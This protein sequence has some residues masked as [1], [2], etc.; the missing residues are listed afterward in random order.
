MSYCKNC[1]TELQSGARFC[2]FCGTPTEIDRIPIQLNGNGEP[3]YTGSQP[4]GNGEPAYTGGQPL[5]NGESPYAGGQP[6]G[7]AGPVY[8]NSQPYG[9]GEPAY[10][11]S[12]PL[13]NGE[14]P[15]AGGQPYGN[16]EPTYVSGQPYGNV[17]PV[18]ANGQP[19][20]N[21]GP[22]YAGGQ[23]YGNGEPT[24]ANGQVYGNGEQSYPNMSGYAGED[25][26]FAGNPYSPYGAA[27]QPQSSRKALM[28]IGMTVGLIVAVALILLI[29]L[30]ARDNSHKTYQQAVDIFM[31]GL[32]K[33][34]MGKMLEAFPE[35][36]RG[37]MRRELTRYYDSEQELWEEYNENLEWYCGNHVK[38]TYK[39]VQAEPLLEYQIRDLEQDLMEDFQ[40]DVSISSGYEVDI[41]MT[42]KGSEG[43]YSDGEMLVVAKIDG[44]WYVIGY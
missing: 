17:G 39:I 11:G 8:A 24:Y 15:Y 23:P 6:Y 29:V 10:T 16:G 33:Q 42:Y 44:K 41:E 12:Q 30:L 34:D 27:V 19:Y 35:R 22:V 1:G 7:N 13:G 32:E 40:Y 26:Y 25:G 3:A 2:A 14:S 18:Y 5:G 36:L 21:A 4:L 43:E 9:N 20:E 38:M 37:D 31:N 28:I